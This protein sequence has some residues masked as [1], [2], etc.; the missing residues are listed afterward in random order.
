MQKFKKVAAGLLLGLLLAG[1][2]FGGDDIGADAAKAKAEA[3]INSDLLTGGVKATILEAKDEAGL[4]HIKIQLDENGNKRE[5]ESY[6]T[7]DG[8]LLFPQAVE[9]LTAEEKEAKA[10]EA[11]EA[12]KTDTAA[13]IADTPK[14]DKPVVELFVMSH[15]PFG[16]QAEKGILPVI[17]ALGDN[18]DFQLK[19]VDYAM[20]DEEELV[21]QTREV[22]IRQN[23][24]TKL[25]AYLEKFLEAGDSDAAITAA[26]L[27][28]AQVATWAKAVDAE[29]KIM[30]NFQ[31]KTTW[32]NGTY[33]LFPVDAEKVKAY[34]VQGSP[35]LVI[36]GKVINSGRDST[37]LL[38]A[39]CGAFTTAPAACEAKLSA[40]VPSSGFGYTAAVAGN[41]DG[42]CS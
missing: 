28:A 18:V 38:E 1:C 13:A 33:P 24:P 39:I 15:C 22:A 6:V 23:A 41:E 30:E 29:F 12:A 4:Y 21:E 5:V 26:G 3:F 2:S 17:K 35:T 27:D 37:S 20:H 7:K 32:N 19:F 8:K 9:M 11:A 25:L 10:K 42:S 16:T 14:T 31:D 40:E 34:G 36:N